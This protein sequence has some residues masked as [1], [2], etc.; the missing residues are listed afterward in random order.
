M[1]RRTVR[2]SRFQRPF[3]SASVFLSIRS[4]RSFASF[5]QRGLA[6]WSTHRRRVGGRTPDVLFPLGRR[7]LKPAL[8]HERCA[9]DLCPRPGSRH[10]ER[11]LGPDTDRDVHLLVLFLPALA[12]LAR[13]CVLPPPV[14]AG[15]G[16]ET[17]TLGLFRTRTRRA[18]GCGSS[19]LA[20]PHPPTHTR[21]PADGGGRTRTPRGGGRGG[22]RE[23]TVQTRSTWEGKG[24][25]RPWVGSG[26]E[27]KGWAGYEN[28][29]EKQPDEGSGDSN[30]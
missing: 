19:P 24:R 28:D 11:R 26:I 30:V 18:R 25:K 21:T 8:D 14:G 6:T 2:Q 12:P 1:Q 20:L 5:S 22:G 9:C 10:V 3:G 13:S 7:P 16:F 27:G 29:V 17:R 15:F 4:F 23:G